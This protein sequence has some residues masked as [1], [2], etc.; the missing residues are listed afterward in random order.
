MVIAWGARV[1]VG[2]ISWWDLAIALGIIAFWPIQEWLIHVFILH[3]RPR[4]IL[5]RS[6]DLHV[7]EKHRLHHTAPW[8]LSDVFVPIRTLLRVLFLGLPAFVLVWSIFLPLSI[9][10]T[11]V[12]VFATFGL[13]YEWIHY[14]VHTGWK[15]RSKWYR[16][17][18]QHHRWHHFKNEN[19]W[20]GVSRLEGDMLL[21]TAPDSSEVETSPTARNLDGRGDRVEA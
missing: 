5:G 10:L 15:P 4:T 18:W 8:V 21:G 11:G 9:G 7:A 13:V 20:Y 12:A 6:V 14:L 2:S 1:A 16:K 19:Y 3:F 17:L